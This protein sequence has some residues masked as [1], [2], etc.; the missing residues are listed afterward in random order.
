MLAAIRAGMDP[1]LAAAQTRAIQAELAAADATIQSWESSEKAPAALTRNQVRAALTEARGL[2]GLLAAAGR[3]DRQ[4]LYRAL[5][6][7]LRYHKEA[8]TGLERVQ[9][10]LELRSS[11]GRI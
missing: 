2:I 10:R 7:N 3:Q 8:P 9:A 4:A 5:R 6:L 11:G 1:A